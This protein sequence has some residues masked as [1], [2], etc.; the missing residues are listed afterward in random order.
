MRNISHGALLHGPMGGDFRASGWSQ[1]LRGPAAP[2][3]VGEPFTTRIKSFGPGY[4]VEQGPELLLLPV[5]FQHEN[6]RNFLLQLISKCEIMFGDCFRF[7]DPQIKIFKNL[8]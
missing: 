2:P 8:Q 5:N 3:V 6:R 7:S 4:A 1:R